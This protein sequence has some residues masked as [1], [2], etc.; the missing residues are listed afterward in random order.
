MHPN[1]NIAEFLAGAGLAKV[2]DWHAGILSSSGGLDRL[3]AAEKSAKDKRIGI[4]EKYV[5]PAS[6]RSQTNGGANGPTGTA[7]P[8]SKGSSFDATV[9]RIWSADT[10][11]VVAKGDSDA[12]E[13]KLQLASVRGPRWV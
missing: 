10:I 5:P 12:K 9:V 7:V 2:V 4:W 3:R 6:A 13:R 1:G 8:T 11:S